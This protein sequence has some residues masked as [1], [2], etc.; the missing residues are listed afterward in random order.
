MIH[1][2]TAILTVSYLALA[3]LTYGADYAYWTNKFPILDSHETRLSNR[4][5][6]FICAVL[7]P[8]AFW[9]TLFWTGFFYYGLQFSGGP[10]EKFK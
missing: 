10:K 6:A 8:V 5:D 3:I 2:E 7:S 9:L 1:R 4:R